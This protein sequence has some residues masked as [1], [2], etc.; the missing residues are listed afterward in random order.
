META[1]TVAL[2]YPGSWHDPVCSFLRAVLADCGTHPEPQ[3]V[4]ALVRGEKGTELEPFLL[5]EKDYTLAGLLGAIAFSERV[6]ET[7]FRI[8]SRDTIGDRGGYILTNNLRGYFAERY[9]EGT[10]RP[11][12]QFS[13]AFF[14][15]E[16]AKAARREPLVG[17]IL[18][19]AKVGLWL[20]LNWRPQRHLSNGLTAIALVGPA[21]KDQSSSLSFSDRLQYNSGIIGANQSDFAQL[22]LRVN[23][24][25][26]ESRG[27]AIVSLIPGSSESVMRFMAL[28]T[29]NALVGFALNDPKIEP[30]RDHLSDLRAIYLRLAL[31][32]T[33]TCTV[34]L[35][36]VYRSAMATMWVR[37]PNLVRSVQGSLYSASMEQYCPGLTAFADSHLAIPPGPEQVARAMRVLQ[38]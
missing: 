7:R 3:R 5:S 24:D 19:D 21:E 2:L 37:F 8:L 9:V 26:D 38:A 4:E 27:A 15:P 35:I 36:S 12:K 11:Q 13:G 6:G 23:I 28:C 17:T 10:R 22:G 25:S 18:T 20:R 30:V 34:P 32:E 31:P 16:L 1:V 33:D 29:Q 14:A